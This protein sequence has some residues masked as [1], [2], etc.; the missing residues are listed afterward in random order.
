MRFMLL[1][2]LIPA[3]AFTCLAAAQSKSSVS[4]IGERAAEIIKEARKALGGQKL[5]SL[6]NLTAKGKF[7]ESLEEN[8]TIEGSFEFFVS[9][10]DKFLKAETKTLFGPDEITEI[11][12]MNGAD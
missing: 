8:K 7:S 12:A 11:Q 3:L 1:I 4:T 6:Q 2:L 5:D 9:L 10:P